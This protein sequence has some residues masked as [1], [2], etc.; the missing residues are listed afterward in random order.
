MSEP[1]G[2]DAA[3]TDERGT[4]EKGRRHLNSAPEASG[5]TA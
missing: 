3:W 1:K 5:V 2:R 4:S